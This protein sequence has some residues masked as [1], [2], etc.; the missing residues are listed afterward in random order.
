MINIQFRG[1]V[2]SIVSISVFNTIGNRVVEINES[3]SIDQQM[4]IDLSD[5]QPGVYYLN[6]K[7]GDDVILKKVTLTR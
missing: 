2:S 6:I 1:D 4:Q 3:N 7:T 5:Y